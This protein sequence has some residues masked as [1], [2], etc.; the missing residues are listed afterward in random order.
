[1]IAQTKHLHLSDKCVGQ[2]FA[3]KVKTT[4]VRE[5]KVVLFDILLCQSHTLACKGNSKTSLAID[6]WVFKFTFASYCLILNG[7]N[8]TANNS[9][10]L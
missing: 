4:D 2:L 7:R 1:M 3:G 6:Q 8:A 9:L 5:K 10:W